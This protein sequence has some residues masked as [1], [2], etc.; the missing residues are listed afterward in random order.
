MIFEKVKKP[1]KTKKAINAKSYVI[2]AKNVYDKYTWIRYLKW[3]NNYYRER[4]K[5]FLP[6]VEIINKDP[7][8]TSSI[9]FTN[10][11]KNIEQIL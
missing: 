3:K 7:I 1:H 4:N 9:Y 11:E 10:R 2:S 8:D 6:R 5:I